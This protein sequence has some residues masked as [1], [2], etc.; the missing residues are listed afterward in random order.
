LSKVHKPALS[1]I[2]PT[3]QR[4]DSLER[5]LH[6]LAATANDPDAVEIVLVMDA[7]DA[8]SVAFM[9]PGLALTRVIVQPGMTMGALNLAGYRASAGVLLML[10]NDDVVARTSGW[11][12][13]ICRCF[14]DYP[15]QILLVHCNDLV[16]ED[17][18][19]TFPVVSRRFCELAGGICP[20]AYKRYRID[21]HIED[22][23]N[24]L[25]LLGER[26]TIYLPGVVF[27]HLHFVVHPE[28]PRQYFSKEEVLAIDAPEF[29]RLF[30]ARKELAL[31]LKAHIAGSASANQLAAWKN[32]LEAVHDWRD[33]R[34]PGRQRVVGG[35][36]YR[37]Q[38]RVG[39]AARAL[40][41]GRERVRTCIRDKG[42]GGLARAMWR[43]LC[44]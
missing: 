5:L 16:F 24:L 39:K 43:R 4:I 23:F 21:D 32:R 22:I 7:D 36:W 2:L 29:E 42:Y 41:R 27:E 14:H 20:P 34:V 31:R 3:R 10:L 11:D 1:L 8:E 26:R 13:T 38:A 44:G 25:A 35:T 33:L 6:S 12:R 18:L 40:A 9:F 17:K 37:M 19:C 15:D 28:G 30:P